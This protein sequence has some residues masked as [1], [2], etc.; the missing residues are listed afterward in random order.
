MKDNSVEI[1]LNNVT[2][3]LKEYHN[4]DW[5]IKLGTVFAVFDQQDSGNISFGVEKDEHKKFI[6]YAGAQ[7]IAF[8]GT[9][10]HAIKRLKNSVTI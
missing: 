4:F 10:G 7:T 8:E 2:F 5:L 1:Q 3:Q 6:K 9:T